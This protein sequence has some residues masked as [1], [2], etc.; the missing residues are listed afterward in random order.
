[1]AAQGLVLVVQTTH[2]QL[3]CCACGTTEV[4]PWEGVPAWVA[5]HRQPRPLALLLRMNGGSPTW[6]RV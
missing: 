5:S 2:A 1:M 6:H 4:T 3:H